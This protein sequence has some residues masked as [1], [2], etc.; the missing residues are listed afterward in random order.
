LSSDDSFQKTLVDH[1]GIEVDASVNRSRMTEIDHR[2][3]NL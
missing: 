1:R 3:L 2:R